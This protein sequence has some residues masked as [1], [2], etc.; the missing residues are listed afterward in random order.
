MRRSLIVVV[1]MFT[2]A[3]PSSVAPPTGEMVETYALLE[4]A[5]AQGGDTYAPSEMKEARS[6]YKQ[7][8]KEF[9]NGS[10]ETA[11]ELRFISEIRAKTAISISRRKLYENEIERLQSEISEANSIKR[12]NEDELRE[13]SSKL[14]QTKGRNALSQEIIRSNALDALE[15]AGDKIKA[16]EKASAGDFDPRV[17]S[18]AR[19][20]YKE[21]QESFNEG[22]YERT[23][24]FAEKT[25]ALAERAYGSSKKQS[26]LRD[27]VLQRVSLI[28][29]A[30]SKPIKEGIRVTLGGIFAPS[31]KIILYDAY[32][33]LDALGGVLTEYP[34]LR[35]VIE[36]YTSDM[37]SE[38]ENLKLSQ[39][40]SETVKD[41]FVS[42]GLSP[43]RFKAEGL[44]ASKPLEK[45]RV[46]NRHIEFTLELFDSR[47]I[48]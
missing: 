28:Y 9:D 35:V 2:L 38:T 19:E 10:R 17:L 40:Q 29:R 33:S 32:P 4:D 18:D 46:K 3:C 24:E 14:E 7:A 44:G 43:E 34:N 23:N 25:A 16:A 12:T 26:D 41:Y 27:E 11:E 39:T 30:E 20:T 13:N 45:D 31:G 5:K 48:Q 15:K 21:A 37:K 6:F 42:K 47:N 8:V 1:L 22:E 36:A